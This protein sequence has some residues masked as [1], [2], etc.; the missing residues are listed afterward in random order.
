MGVVYE[1]VHEATG[2]RYALKALPP[3]LGLGSVDDRR[4][5]EREARVLASLRHPGVVTV[6]AAALE[7]PSPYL[8]QTLLPGGSLADRLEAGPLPVAEV[9]TVGVKLARALAHVHGRGVLHR[10]LKPG[11][12]LFDERGEPRLVDFGLARTDGAQAL[13]RSGTLLGT[14]AYMAPE[15]ARGEPADVRTDVYGLGAVLYHAL[16]G[17]APCPGRSP[18]AVLATVAE[19]RPAPLRR[20]RPDVPPPLEAVVL[21]AMGREP[22]ARFATAADLAGALRG[23]AVGP[24]GSRRV[25]AALLGV[26]AAAVGLAAALV[27]GAGALGPP[28]SEV[29]APAGREASPAEG[30]PALAPRLARLQS[31]AEAALRRDEPEAALKD[32]AS[33]LAASP[34]AAALP[35]WNRL[36]ERAR[37]LAGRLSPAEEAAL[38]GGRRA[39]YGSLPDRSAELRG[40]L[41]AAPPRF[42]AQAWWDVAP[43]WIAAA[44]VLVEHWRAA[45]GGAREGGRRLEPVVEEVLARRLVD[46][47][48]RVLLTVD[49]A[50]V[51]ESRDLVADVDDVLAELRGLAGEHAGPRLDPLEVVADDHLRVD[52]GSG[53]A[54]TEAERRES[55]ARL[56]R[57]E[58]APLLLER[59]RVLARALLVSHGEAG[60]SE[61]RRWLGPAPPPGLPP[62]ATWPNEAASVSEAYSL[63]VEGALRRLTEALAEGAEAGPER[64]AR[65]FAAALDVSLTRLAYACASEGGSLLEVE[66]EVADVVRILLMARWEE[67]SRVVFDVL[68]AGNYPQHRLVRAELALLEADWV[69]AARR[70][71]DFVYDLDDGRP[72]PDPAAARAVHAARAPGSPFDRAAELGAARAAAAGG[73]APLL[74]WRTAVETEAELRGAGL[75]DRLTDLLARAGVEEAPTVARLRALFRALEGVLTSD[76]SEAWEEVHARLPR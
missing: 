32:V 55:R 18:A 57:V 59:Q 52:A 17:R 31:D 3:G 25:S 61:A 54:R 12:V 58:A 22:A 49:R 36:G 41:A 40:R 1:A 34:P 8:V 66:S 19:G 75:R 74:P 63:R 76:G 21:R 48:A 15:Q 23:A 35:D 11:N 38:H 60:P 42:D 64:V 65:R 28:A 2:Q 37:F 4:R 9:V 7:E 47:V 45:L 27:V 6:H 70:L 16:A 53:G 68:P 73:A 51:R 62:G 44:G 71:G 20:L 30:G 69:S 14:P 13:T 43:E 67:A 33:A 24:G 26:V 72:R 5:I 10:D 29:G 39:A 46:D 50:A 56:R